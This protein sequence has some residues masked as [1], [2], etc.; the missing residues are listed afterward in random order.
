MI[1]TK[2]CLQCNNQFN[3]PVTESQ[4]NWDN[5]HKFCSISCKN[6]SEK[7]IT[8]INSG[9]FTKDKSS[10]NKGL[11]GY[12]AGSK[13]NMWKG[14]QLNLNCV[15]CSKQFN[16][17]PYRKNSKCCSIACIKK[18]RALPNVRLKQ[19]ELTRKQILEQYGGTPDFVS[20]VTKLVR[21]SAK[22]KIWRE[23][24]WERDNYTCQMCLKQKGK[25]C[26]DHILS[27]LQV[28]L[29]ENIDSY[30]KAMESEKLWDI[31][32]GR[33][34]CFDCHFK[35]ENFGFKAIKLANIINQ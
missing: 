33:T 11:K 27:F 9:Q 16:V 2:N 15:I 26:A 21:G 29:S 31:S 6:L 5:R 22:Y 17:D 18:Y 12:N 30:D 8:K 25:I 35:T 19:S 10:W 13:N 34:L 23:Q 14:G 1:Q 20:S 24:V 4:K 7:G 3:K 28:L 32:N